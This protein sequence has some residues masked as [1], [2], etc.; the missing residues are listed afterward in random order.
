MLLRNEPL[1]ILDRDGVINYDSDTY[2]KTPEEWIPIP[3]SLEAIAKL[4]KAGIKIVVATNQSGIARGYYDET[5]L[6]LIHQKMINAINSLGGEL[7]GI[8][9]CPHGPDANCECRKPKAGLI[10]RISNEL[11]IN[12]KNAPFVGDSI[13][14]IEA[15]IAG[16][17]QPVLVKT[18]NGEE[19]AKNS[20]LSVAIYEDLLDFS[21]HWLGRTK[22]P[23]N[24]TR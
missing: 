23:P 19:T 5:M 10:K 11:Q 17:C 15:A 8:F 3:G 24:L 12:T 13:R 16:G 1:V 9:Y 20:T 21:T 18:G 14:D 6:S 2:I 4:S 7:A 22:N